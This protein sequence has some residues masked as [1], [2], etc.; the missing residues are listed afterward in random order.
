MGCAALFCQQVC[1][2]LKCGT[3]WQMSQR[4]F[5]QSLFQTGNTWFDNGAAIWVY[6]MCSPTLVEPYHG[7][8][9]K[10]FDMKAGTAAAFCW[11]CQGWADG[12][13]ADMS[14]FKVG[15]QELMF[16]CFNFCR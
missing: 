12:S 14:A 5:D 4:K 7:C 15:G 9:G 1:L 8:V 13:R 10:T 6:N 3:N 11:R 2:S 16:P